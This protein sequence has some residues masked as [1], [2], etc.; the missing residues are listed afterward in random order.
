MHK[1]FSEMRTGIQYKVG[2]QR[3]SHLENTRRGLLKIIQ[4]IA[5]EISMCLAIMALHKDSEKNFSN[6]ISPR[7][8]SYVPTR[9]R[10]KGR[11]PEMNEETSE[12]S[13]E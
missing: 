4:Y 10:T 6:K 2:A 12:Y 5:T 3:R 11:R 9:T 1:K 13:S 7:K 8:F